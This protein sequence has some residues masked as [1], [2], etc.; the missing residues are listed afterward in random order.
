MNW[1]TLRYVFG[2]EK[3]DGYAEEITQRP[4][5]LPLV[6]PA[7][8]FV[9]VAGH[10]KTDAT[11]APVFFLPDLGRADF[12]VFCPLKGVDSLHDVR[13]FAKFLNA[14][15]EKFH[16]GLYAALIAEPITHHSDES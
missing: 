2:E 16:Q 4:W 5:T 7:I 8:F 6:Q 3:E 14:E 1:S 15:F 13:K 10:K 12:S 11:S 9:E